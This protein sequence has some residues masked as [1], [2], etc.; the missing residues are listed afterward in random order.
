[1]T[2][3]SSMSSMSQGS[4][5]RLLLKYS[6]PAA[7]GL[8]ANALYNIVDR[9]FIGQYIG[10]DALGAV[11]LTY[12]L[13]LFMIAV[14]SLVGVGGASQISRFLGEGHH[15]KAEHVVG[16]AV[17]VI[18]LLSAL[19]TAGGLLCLDGLIG[20]LGASVHL[21]P[22]TRVYTSIIL[23]GLPF[24]LLGF[25]L[26]YLIRAEGAPR[27]AMGTMMIGAGM[28]VFLDWLFIVRLSM[29]VAGAALG[30]AV[31][32]IAAF[33]WVALF[34]LGR[35]GRLRISALTL[36]PDVEIVKEML[37]IGAS[38]FLMELF[39]SVSMMLYNNVVWRHGGDLAISAMGIFFCLDNLIYIPVFGIGEGL[40]PIV[41]YNYGAQNSDRVKKT[42]ICATVLSTAYFILSFVCTEI[43]T[44]SMVVL[45]A[46]GKES[47]VQLA[48]RAMRIGYLGMPFAAAGIIASNAFLAIGKPGIS[49][50]LNFCRQELL[51]LPALLFMPQIMGL[52]GAWGSFIVVDAGGGLLGAALLAWYW[53][54]FDGEG[55]DTLD[56]SAESAFDK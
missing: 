49:L 48:V 8:V 14:G 55:H 23:W 30:T 41:G 20:A 37:L 34:Y 11:S 32:Q 46:G 4:V 21:A 25:S 1:M 27:W 33:L 16:S 35:R 39:Y 42:V 38:P 10:S 12:P 53:S 5:T 45:F 56:M 28:N 54:L 44:R 31:A 43:W 18:T 51:F 3:T 2:Q 47:L 22:P 24:N 6:V 36:N 17:T 7:L 52:D 50:F 13:T 29:G 15:R 40:Q 26:N 19:F 9:L